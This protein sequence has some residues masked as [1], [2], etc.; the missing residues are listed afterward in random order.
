MGQVESK[1]NN[2]NVLYS[3]NSA[4]D[5]GVYY[6][7]DQLAMV[8]S[9]DYFTPIVDDPYQFGQIAVANAVSDIYAMGGDVKTA[10]N[11]VGFSVEKY[12]SDI[13]A[14]ILQGAEDKMAETGGAI[15]GGHSIDDDEPKFGLAVT[16]FAHPN[17]IWTNGNAKPGDQLIL[18]KPIGT[19]IATT[20]IKKGLADESLQTTTINWMG[21]LNKRAKSILQQYRPNAV[22]DV[23]GF[24]LLGH[25]YEIAENSHVLLSINYDSV[26]VI[27]GVDNYL[28]QGAVPG[29]SKANLSWLK[30]YVTFDSNLNRDDQLLLTDAVTSGGLLISLNP[31]DAEQFIQEMNES[32][33][34]LAVTIGEVVNH[35]TPHIMVSY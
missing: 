34:H 1:T 17:H 22:T 19:G 10:L 28:K 9:V 26:P 6:I 30:D 3:Q 12:G 23:T 31:Q 27:E 16:G 4:D 24:G 2:Q 21:Q 15:I 18:T 32:P 5:A 14:S 35:Q 7:D 20:A 25:A 8:Q 13:L 29:G 33:D 11:I